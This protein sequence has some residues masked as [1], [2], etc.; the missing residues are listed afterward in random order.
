MDIDPSPSTS[1]GFLMDLTYSGLPRIDENNTVDPKSP[2]ERVLELLDILESHVEKLRRE[3]AQ[4]EEDRDHLL[5]SLDSVRNT[6][7]IVDLPDNDRD[8]VCQYAERIMSR[9]LT[10]EVKILT[11]RDKMQ[12]E[13]LHQ[14]NHLIDS[15]VMCVKSDPESA[16]ARCITFMNACSSN[17]VHGITDKKFESALLGCTVDDQK[18][19]KKRLQGLLNYFD[20]LNVT[21][22]P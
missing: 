6:D 10:V 9:C 13:A 7:L 18:R 22:I 4:L 8:D 12:E 11:Q 14:V 20:K 3:A 17:V 2:K 16:K 1:S 21:S 5:S 19:V 15:L